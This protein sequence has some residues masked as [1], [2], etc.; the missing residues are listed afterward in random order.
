MRLVA[1]EL[2]DSA[3]ANVWLLSGP[4]GS[5]KTVFARSVLR[6]LGFRGAVPSPTFTLSRHYQTPRGRWTR[7]VHIDAYRIKN[8]AEEAALDITDAAQDPRCLVLIEWPERLASQLR[9]NAL[10]LQFQH[11]KTGRVVRRLSH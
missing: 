3:S 10:R 1:E 4:L 2:V 6:I 5:G 11:A 8:Q 9:T 7:V